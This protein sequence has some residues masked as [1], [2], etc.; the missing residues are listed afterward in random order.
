MPDL[1]TRFA[2]A[3][4]LPLVSLV[5]K[6]HETQPQKGQ[7]NSSHQETNVRG[8]FA[9]V[10]APLQEPCFLIDDMVDSRWTL[11]EI[12]ELLRSNGSG[13]VCPLA[14]GSLQGRDS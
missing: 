2:E 5:K 12:G 3:L 1:A 9:L 4:S 8:A 14:L 10:A 6:V 13:P 11:V 7:Q